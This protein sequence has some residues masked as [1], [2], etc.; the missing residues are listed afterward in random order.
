MH[1]LRQISLISAFT[2][3]LTAGAGGQEYAVTRQSFGI[4]SNSLEIE[5]LATA[6][7]QLQVIRGS[8]GRVDVAAYAARGVAAFGLTRQPPVLRLTALGAIGADYVVVVPERASVRVRLP[9][10]RTW[11]NVNGGSRAFRW[12]SVPEPRELDYRMPAP[13]LDGR[14]YV[15]ATSPAAPERVRLLNEAHVRSIELRLEGT[16]FRIASSRPLVHSPGMASRIDVDA[17]DEDVDLMVQVPAYTADFELHLGSKV[18]VVL[19]DSQ[20]QDLCGPSVK[21][22][23]PEGF[24]RI[25]FRPAEGL[26]CPVGGGS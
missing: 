11:E 24:W 12:D 19:K 1:F 20:P 21:Q 5:V 14:F 25:T 18:L 4:Y 9:G 16:E 8:D 10:R 26:K 22:R 15:V 6:P 17:G 7:G 23:N 3:T 13:T 2:A